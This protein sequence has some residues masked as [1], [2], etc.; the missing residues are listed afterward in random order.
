MAS[1]A[2]PIAEV[3]GEAQPPVHRYSSSHGPDGRLDVAGGAGAHPDEL[4][5]R[6]MTT[7]P[8]EVD[9][10]TRWRAEGL[11]RQGNTV[12]AVIAA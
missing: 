12:P 5:R 11:W 4:P 7:H 6:V 9:A 10:G 2:G 8:A 3:E 1:T